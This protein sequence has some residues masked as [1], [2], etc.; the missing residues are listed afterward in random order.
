MFQTNKHF[1]QTTP[2]HTQTH[3][4]LYNRTASHPKK[5]LHGHGSRL[6]TFHEARFTAELRRG[7]TSRDQRAPMQSTQL[8][9]SDSHGTVH[10][11]VHV[12]PTKGMGQGPGYQGESNTTAS[13]STSSVEPEDLGWLE[14]IMSYVGCAA[15]RTQPSHG[16]WPAPRNDLLP[17]CGRR[18]V[19]DMLASEAMEGFWAPAT[20]EVVASVVEGTDGGPAAS[21]TDIRTAVL[22]HPAN[23][24]AHPPPTPEPPPRRSWNKGSGVREVAWDSPAP[25]TMTPPAAC[26]ESNPVSDV[27]AAA[28]ALAAALTAAAQAA[29]QA[30]EAAAASL[31]AE[32][33]AAF[34]PAAFAPAEPMEQE[35][36]G[37]APPS[38]GLG[39]YRGSDT[40]LLSY[41]TG[42]SEVELVDE[43]LIAPPPQPS[44]GTQPS[45]VT[46]AATPTNA[47]RL[48]GDNA[49][50]T[51]SASSSSRLQRL[52]TWRKLRPEATKEGQAPAPSTSASSTSGASSGGTA[53]KMGRQ[54]SFERM[55][56]VGRRMRGLSVQSNVQAGAA[57]GPKS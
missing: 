34:A 36:L 40:S 45:V 31:A 4:T 25:A 8:S 17:C 15:T 23:P 46:P 29:A 16:D 6:H 21:P 54:S 5:L 35:P 52:P 39:R 37:S 51:S 3:N 14:Q 50:G 44:V 56:S 30:A 49:E 20:K 38:P 24:P 33:T 53:K 41:C 48:G 22:A 11:T 7:Q 55:R 57:E 32:A 47:Q 9:A 13:P 43:E 2:P 26:E 28:A 42:D 1:P 19:D 12:T 10:A 27:S 18:P